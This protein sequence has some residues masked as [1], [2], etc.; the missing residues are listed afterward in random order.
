M[1]RDLAWDPPDLGAVFGRALDGADEVT[2]AEPIDERLPSDSLPPA[3]GLTTLRALLFVLTLLSAAAALFVEPALAGAVTRGALSARWLFLP[4]G[5]Y[6]VFLGAYAFDRIWLVRDRRYPAGKAFFQIAFGVVFASLLLPETI[7][8]YKAQSVPRPDRLLSHKDPNVREAAV[9][10]LGF[11]GPAPERTGIVVGRLDDENAS[12]R[13]AALRV[14]QRWSGE[15]E[16]G[17][18]RLRRWASGTRTSS[19]AGP[20]PMRGSQ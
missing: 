5:V 11:E 16:A 12:V 17:P 6:G 13:R 9:L 20:G 7:Q 14:L 4:I 19:A 10:A 8:D 3:P 1:C 18:E 15:P 2:E